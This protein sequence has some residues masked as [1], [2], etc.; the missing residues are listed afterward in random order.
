MHAE[1]TYVVLKGL[2]EKYRGKLL[3]VKSPKTVG[4]KSTLAHLTLLLWLPYGST[5]LVECL[6]TGVVLFFFLKKRV[7]STY[8]CRYARADVLSGLPGSQAES[9]RLSAHW[10]GG[11]QRAAQPEET[12]VAGL[13]GWKKQPRSKSEGLNQG[14]GACTERLKKVETTIQR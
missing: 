8:V 7:N 4:S 3:L 14:L 13:E 9:P 11:D 6:R 2:L 12:G 10:K 5:D 1:I